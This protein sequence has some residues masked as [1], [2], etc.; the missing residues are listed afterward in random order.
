MSLANFMRYSA[1]IR[2]QKITAS[3]SS[4]LTCRIGAWIDFAT[5]VQYSPE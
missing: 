3:G 2:A 1:A 4:P 5:S